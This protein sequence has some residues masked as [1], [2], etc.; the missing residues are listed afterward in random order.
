MT[1]WDIEPIGDAKKKQNVT[2]NNGKKKPQP[3]DRKKWNLL[4]IFQRPAGKKA[5]SPAVARRPK[6]RRGGKSKKNALPKRRGPK[7]RI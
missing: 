5:S 6:G 7:L 1:Y 2:K 3:G 4:V